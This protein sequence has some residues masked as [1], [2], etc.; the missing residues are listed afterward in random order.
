MTMIIF[1]HIQSIT[2]NIPVKVGYLSMIYRLADHHKFFIGRPQK[3]A[4]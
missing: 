3:N 4:V 2:K 1:I